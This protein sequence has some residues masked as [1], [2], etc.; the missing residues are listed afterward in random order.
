MQAPL[1]RSAADLNAARD[2]CSAWL[3]G[4]LPRRSMREALTELAALPQAEGGLDQ[5]GEGALIDLL[6]RRVATLVGKPAALFMHKGVAAQL[7]ALRVWAADR[8]HAPVALH[9]Q[10]HIELD[11]SLAYEQLM[12]LRSLR[13]G[14][15]D[16]PLQVDDLRALAVERPSAVVAE[17]PLRRGGYRLPPWDDLVALSLWC[18]EHQVPLHFDG[19][20]LWEASPFYGREPAAIAALADSVYVSFYKGLGGLGGCVLAGSE[21]FIARVRPWQT[22]LA[23]NLYTV[24]PYV[25]SAMAGLDRHLPRM[26]AYRE[27]ALGLAQALARVPGARI[28]P[29]P[30]QTNSFQLHLP[31]ERARLDAALASQAQASGF[32]V[33]GRSAHSIWPGH[34]MIEVVVGDAAD[35]WTDAQ[36]AGHVEAVLRVAQAGDARASG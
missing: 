5:Y 18:R 32:W 8:P 33:A 36:A 22:R 23:G 31:V 27:R 34:A 12:G 9:R 17:L 11:E 3:S 14:G 20:R 19:A 7:A 28:A 25:L 24:F 21:D 2:A 16:Q 30:P 29:E 13:V 35:H 10:S 26:A 4:H 6:Q 15:I 1:T